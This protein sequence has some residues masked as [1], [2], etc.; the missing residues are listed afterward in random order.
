MAAWL[1][2]GNLNWQPPPGRGLRVD[3]ANWRPR[4][5]GGPGPGAARLG[6]QKTVRSV[7]LSESRLSPIN[8][9]GDSEPTGP[10]TRSRAAR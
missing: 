7:P 9:L 4:R 10:Y 5:A 6:K 1:R 2:L 3:S 8:P